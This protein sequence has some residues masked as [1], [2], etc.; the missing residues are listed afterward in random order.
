M[1]LYN[2]VELFAGVGG[3]GYGFAHNGAFDVILANEVDKDI[4]RAY[5]LNYPTVPV[6][7]DDIRN[8]TQDA[9]CKALGGRR[10]DVVVGGP[11]CQSYSTL[12]LRRMDDR[13]HLFRDY[14]RVLSIV[15]PRLFLFE[16]VTGLESMEGGRLLETIKEQFAALGYRLQSRRLNAVNYGVPQYRERLIL[17]GMQGTNTFVYPSP[18]HGE[19][20]LPYRTVA[21]ALGDLPVLA[22]GKGAEKYA[23]PP[24]NEYQRYLRADA[25]EQLAEHNAPQNGAHLVRLMQALPDGGTKA[26]LPPELRPTSGYGNTYAKMWWHRPAPTITRNFAT[27]SSSRCIHPRDSRALTTREGARL[28]SFPDS[29]LFYGARSTK[30]LEIGNAVPP[31]LSIA[32]AQAVCEALDAAIPPQ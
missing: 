5:S 30:N 31:L 7:V 17:I 27:P 12:G 2:V 26:D 11:P 15:R 19:G 3:L 13:A 22:S 24:Q 18:T 16:N 25:S 10:V 14:C 23:T 20:L 9:L 28:Q 4:A 1:S 32:L 6:I 8:L 21:D 29:Y